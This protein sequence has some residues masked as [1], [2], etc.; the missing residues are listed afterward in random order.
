MVFA[1]LVGKPR[2]VLIRDGRD[3]TCAGILSQFGVPLVAGALF[4]SHCYSRT[5]SACRYLWVLLRYLIFSAVY[6]R[7]ALLF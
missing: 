5:V 1:S 6:G 7:G 3:R 4:P 2:V